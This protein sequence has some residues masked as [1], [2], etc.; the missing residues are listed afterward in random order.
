MNQTTINEGKTMAVISYITVI[1][2]LI[3]YIANNSKQNQYT[4]FH[5]GQS[6]RVWILSIVISISLG[7]LSSLLGIHFLEALRWLPFI[8]AIMGAVN[9]YNGKVTKLPF[10]GTI[11]E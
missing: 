10:I 6:I 4:K 5:I 3:A 9:A 2:L 11:G 7:L 1:G 8:F